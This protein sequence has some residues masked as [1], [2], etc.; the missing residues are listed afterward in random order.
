MAIGMNAQKL[1]EVEPK[2]E[3]EKLKLKKKMEENNAR[4]IKPNSNFAMNFLAQ[5][6][7]EL[8]N[9]LEYLL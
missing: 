4:E 3:P 8:N 5:V 6:N 2:L 9:Y 7:R 1:A